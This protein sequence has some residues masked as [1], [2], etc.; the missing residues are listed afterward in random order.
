MNHLLHHT[1]VCR[2]LNEQASIVVA[3]VAETEIDAD[4]DVEDLL[5]KRSNCKHHMIIYIK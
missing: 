1:W 2:T 5:S 4:V 3:S